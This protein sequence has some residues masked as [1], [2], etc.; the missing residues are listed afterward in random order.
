MY[1]GKKF[2]TY[3]VIILNVFFRFLYEH[4][5]KFIKKQHIPHLVIHVNKVVWGIYES[6]I[7]PLTHIIIRIS[8]YTIQPCDLPLDLHCDLL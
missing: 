8:L 4:S 1:A 6:N 2:G 5:S 7:T 3:N